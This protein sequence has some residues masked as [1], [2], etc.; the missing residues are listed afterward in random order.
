MRERGRV[1]ERDR[2]GDGGRGKGERERRHGRG[3]EDTVSEEMG[4]NLHLPGGT[5]NIIAVCSLK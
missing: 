1:Y 4:I 2:D 3:E 5:N